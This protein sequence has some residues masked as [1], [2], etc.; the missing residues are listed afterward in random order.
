MVGFGKHISKSVCGCAM[1]ASKRAAAGVRFGVLGSQPGV[2]EAH[3][4]RLPA[5]DSQIDV[6]VTRTAM[7]V[8]NARR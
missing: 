5:Y 6:F 2:I 4:A 3:V 8:L 1:G 7:G